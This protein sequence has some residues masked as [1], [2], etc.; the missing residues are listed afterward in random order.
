MTGRLL[1]SVMDLPLFSEDT[2]DLRIF[3]RSD[4]HEDRDE[5]LTSDEKDEEVDI[6]YIK[7]E[8]D[9]PADVKHKVHDL[10]ECQANSQST[11]RV[12]NKA[13][14]GIEVQNSRRGDRVGLVHP[15]AAAGA[16]WHVAFAQVAAIM[17][18]RYRA[19]K[20]GHLALFRQV[21]VG[22]ASFGWCAR[23]A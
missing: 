9:P 13:L 16:Q 1:G 2:P 20:P 5:P 14:D 6:G 10:D 4:V 22:A 18:R 17:N 23:G 7:L 15:L 19:H 12:A 11:I 3:D 8:D 21:F